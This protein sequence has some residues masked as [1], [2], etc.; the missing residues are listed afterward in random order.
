MWRKDAALGKAFVRNEA[1]EM[2]GLRNERRVET[3]RQPPQEAVV[4]V[5]ALAHGKDDLV[6]DGF[7]RGCERSGDL[8]MV[9]SVLAEPSEA[10]SCPESQSARL[11]RD[12]DRSTKSHASHRRRRQASSAGLVD[13]FV[14]GMSRVLVGLPAGPHVGR[15]GA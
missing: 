11:G 6:T 3:Q 15:R 5:C 12:L 8:E 1:L 2:S 10:G 4:F 14:Q 13:A 7:V 9:P